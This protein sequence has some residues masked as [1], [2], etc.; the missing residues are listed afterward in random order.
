MKGVHNKRTLQRGF[1]LLE[2]M[3]VLV[4]IGIMATA[5]VV[6]IQGNVG[7]A[8]VTRAQS[9]ISTLSDALEFYKTDNFVYPSTEQGLTALRVKPN[10]DPEPRNYKQGG[11]I[12]KLEKDPWGRDYQYIFPGEHGEYDLF[13][14][15]ADGEIGGEGENADIGNWDEHSEGN[16]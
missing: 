13:S 11:Y 7:K 12:R 3:V 8:T 1:T 10:T 15:G 6:N 16:R 14:L 5:I 9:D 4:I 2:I